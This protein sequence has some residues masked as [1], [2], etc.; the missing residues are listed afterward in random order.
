[1]SPAAETHFESLDSE[2]ASALRKR[3]VNAAADAIF[4]DEIARERAASWRVIRAS[5]VPSVE[6]ASPTILDFGGDR[7]VFYPDALN[8]LYGSSDSLKTWIALKAVVSVLAEGGSALVIEYEM[9]PEQ[10]VQRLTNLG[11]S[12]E[13]LMRCGVARPDTGETDAGRELLVSTMAAVGEPS[14]LVIDSCGAAMSRAGLDSNRAGDVEQWV[15][16]LPRWAVVQW[17][18]VAVL[19]VDHTPHEARHATGSKRK[20]DTA[21]AM[22]FVK[23]RQ[24]V[25]R[26]EFGFST[27][28]CEKDRFGAHRH[29]SLVFVFEGGGGQ[30]FSVRPPTTTEA[31]TGRDGG[32]LRDAILAMLSALPA[33]ERITV[34]KLRN[35]P[36]VKAHGNSRAVSDAVTALTNAGL[37]D[38]TQGRG[39][40]RGPN[41]ESE[42]Q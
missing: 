15:H 1:M 7:P 38:R 28:T 33:D 37:L 35:A 4:H 8:W 40:G 18:N 19:V 26:E 2:V 25:S 34:E 22:F 36:Q 20:G 30:P 24:N 13:Q 29:N 16:D 27:V 17:P 39:V 12:P 23:K 6:P 32:A 41:F 5:D 31:R 14:V 42:G 11:A 9:T 3:R 21:D 10:I